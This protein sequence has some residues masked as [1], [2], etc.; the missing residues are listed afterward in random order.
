[1]WPS[2]P[3]PVALHALPCQRGNSVSNL[4]GE[5]TVCRNK[6]YCE[7]DGWVL[8]AERFNGALR[9]IVSMVTGASDC[10]TG[11]TYERD[12]V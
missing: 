9:P 4:H 5:V 3:P 8:Q 11:D 12:P 10:I 2:R 7:L 6:A 1:M